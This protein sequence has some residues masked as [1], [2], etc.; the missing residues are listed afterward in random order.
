MEP[1]QAF[2]S[3]ERPSTDTLDDE[4]GTTWLKLPL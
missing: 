1:L 2:E 4:T 3:K